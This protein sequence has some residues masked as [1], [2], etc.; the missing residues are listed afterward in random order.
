MSAGDSVEIIFAIG[1]VFWLA[2]GGSW[3]SEKAR[4]LK[5]ENDEKE[6]KLNSSKNNASGLAEDSKG[7]V[8]DK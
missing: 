1:I 6:Q 5:L 4:Q 3:V 8:S 2:G 7:V